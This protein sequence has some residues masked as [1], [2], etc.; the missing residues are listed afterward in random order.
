MAAIAMSPTA[1]GEANG[2][3]KQRTEKGGEIAWAHVNNCKQMM[4]NTRQAAERLA[5]E[6]IMT[7]I[8]APITPAIPASSRPR[9]NSERRRSARATVEV[10]AKQCRRVLGFLDTATRFP[11][12]TLSIL[13]EHKVN[14]FWISVFDSIRALAGRIGQYFRTG[15]RAEGNK[16]GDLVFQGG[17]GGR[18]GRGGDVHIGPGIY[19]AG[20]AVSFRRDETRARHGKPGGLR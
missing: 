19:K 7:A 1:S 4:V 9:G 15:G 20:D 13:L 10:G 16:A 5:P 12:L 11:Y 17:N 2:R 3:A 18:Q 14:S 6:C 8:C